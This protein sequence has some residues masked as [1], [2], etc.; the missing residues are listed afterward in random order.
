MS[1]GAN[2]L[3]EGRKDLAAKKIR[4]R[5]ILDLVYEGRNIAEIIPSERPDFLL[6]T[7]ELPPVRG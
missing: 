7:H 1:N 4:E 5:K 3:K 2:G 6:R